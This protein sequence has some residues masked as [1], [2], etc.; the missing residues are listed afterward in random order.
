MNPITFT[1]FVIWAA[2]AGVV[3]AVALLIL[4]DAI[5]EYL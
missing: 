5:K 4:I 2:G 3:A 1:I